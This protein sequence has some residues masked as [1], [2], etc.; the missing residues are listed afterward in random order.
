VR[1]KNVWKLIN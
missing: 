1:L